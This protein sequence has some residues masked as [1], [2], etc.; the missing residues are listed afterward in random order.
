MSC[1]AS[2]LTEVTPARYAEMFLRKSRPP[3]RISGVCG[4][5]IRGTRPE[6]FAKLTFLPGRRL[7]WLTGPTG[8]QMWIGKT[9]NEIVLGIGK[10]KAWLEKKLDEG[11]QWKLVVFPQKACR[12]ADWDGLFSMIREQYPEVADKML[13]WNEDLR[14]SSVADK[15]DRRFVA[16]EVKDREDHPLHMSVERYLTCE[17][18]AENARLFLWHSLGV[19][20]QFTGNGY[21]KGPDG[22]DEYLLP[23]RYLAELPG[24]VVLELSV[25]DPRRTLEGFGSRDAVL[26]DSENCLQEPVGSPD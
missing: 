2:C 25:R 5:V 13:H 7:A 6:E 17:D 12:L 19:N 11:N 1:K 14:D 10:T 23:N 21:T 3:G 26:Q 4:R 24:A 9:G 15:I 18:T 22:V 20:D 8:L 16:S